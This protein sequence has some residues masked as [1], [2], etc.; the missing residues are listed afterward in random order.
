MPITIEHGGLAGTTAGQIIA[1]AGQAELNRQQEAMMQLNQ[2]RQQRDLQKMQIQAQAQLQSQSSDDAYQ[3]IMVGAGLEKVARQELFENSLQQMREQAKAQ[4]QQWEAQYTIKDRQRVASLESGRKLIN[5]STEYT[6][7]EK[8]AANK[9]IDLEIAGISPSVVLKD[10]DKFEFPEERDQFSTWEED[11]ATYGYTY[12]G[13][14]WSKNLVLNPSESL[15]YLR[16]EAVQ[17]ERNRLADLTTKDV[18]GTELPRYGTSAEIDAEIDKR[19]PRWKEQ[20]ATEAFG[21]PSEVIP[22]DATSPEQ[23]GDMTSSGLD[24]RPIDLDLPDNVRD[25]QATIR[26]MKGL[27]DSGQP[28]SKDMELALRYAIKIINEY[29][30]SSRAIE[31]TKEYLNASAGQPTV[32]PQIPTQSAQSYWPAAIPE[33]AGGG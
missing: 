17:K 31:V 29:R 27:K 28:I 10:P 22:G 18:W 20:Q 15:K 1:Q 14:Q 13:N 11:G 4:A 12:R 6:D 32:A 2:L 21:P 19:F 30:A 33:W 26:T 3:R 25:A 9:A 8:K 5:A 23:I 7:D 16:N 24:L